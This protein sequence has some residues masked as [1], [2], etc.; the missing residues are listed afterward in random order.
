MTSTADGSG[1]FLYHSI[2][3]FPGKEARIADGLRKYAQLWSTPSVRA[4]RV[5]SGVDIIDAYSRSP[6]REDLAAQAVCP[7]PISLGS[8]PFAAISR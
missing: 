7:G 4:K 5:A 1:Y 6:S 8:S 3:M 2:G